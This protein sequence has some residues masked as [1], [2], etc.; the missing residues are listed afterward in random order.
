MSQAQAAVSMSIKS[1][2]AVAVKLPPWTSVLLRAN[3]G[4]GKSKV[5]RQA[6]ALVRKELHKKITE[7][8][9]MRTNA[10]EVI[11]LGKYRDLL[12]STIPF[13]PVIDRRLSQM[14]EGDMVGLPST[15]GESTRFN[16]PDW[17]KN[18]CDRPCI[19]FLD[20]IN[21]ATPEVMQAAFQIVLDRELNGWKLHP[22]SR[23][24]AAVNTGA[25]YTVNEMDPA[26]LDRF[27][28]VDLEP[29]LEEFCAWARDTD[30]E[31]G[32]N[33]HP[34]IPDFIQ[35]S[36]RHDGT[37]WLYAPKNAESSGVH[38]SP[39]SW[40]MVHYALEYA[41]L[42]EEPTNELFYNIVRGFVGNEA[43]ISFRD[44]CKSVDNRISGE[45]LV[46]KYH[47][48]KVKAKVK[49]LGQGRQN[50]VV[51]RVAA[52]VIGEVSKLSDRQ[53]DN[54]KELM[55]DLPDE[56]RI[57]LWSK[58][59]SQGIDKIELAK[60]VH[61]HCAELVLGVFGVPM[62]EAG[63]GVV[64]NIPGIFKAPAKTARK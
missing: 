5:V 21:R 17:Y 19:L 26:L 49:R 54:L 33:L 27:Y 32:G 46:N 12:H 48:P 35:G 23:V 11:D 37:N 45:E 62:G 15:D 30:P 9:K 52:F 36:K 7:G 40:E 58:L 44:F 43:S 1:F 14:S 53:G 29:S 24:Y 6:M 61:K 34:N 28:A 55:K 2:K 56:L 64:P 42:L 3:H 41:E 25:A 31:Q 57:S 8:A 51:E 59:T 10:G 13:L 38:P 20:E 22:L 39:R 63:I 18:A 16:P 47:E 4:V 60:S 50:D